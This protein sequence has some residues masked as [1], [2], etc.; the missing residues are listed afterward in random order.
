MENEKIS[1]EPLTEISRQDLRRQDAIYFLGLMVSKALESFGQVTLMM[2]QDDKVA[3][4]N[5]VHVYLDAKAVITDMGD[6]LPPFH[7][8]R[9]VLGHGRPQYVAWKNGELWEISFN[10]PEQSDGH[11]PN[12]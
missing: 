4:A 3:V 1:L 7:W 5:P 11:E 12:P 10:E 2:S 6:P 9:P 8:V